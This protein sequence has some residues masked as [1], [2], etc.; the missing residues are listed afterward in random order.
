MYASIINVYNLVSSYA[1]KQQQG[2]ISPTEF[3]SFAES[4]QM[5]VFNDTIKLLSL[6]LFNENRF[7]SYSRGNYGGK[8]NI[9]DDI[10]TLLVYNQPLTYTGNGFDLPEDYAY[11]NDF[12]YK[13]REIQI[14]SPTEVTMARDNML[15]SPSV[16]HPVGV[17]SQR[18]LLVFP[19]SIVTDVKA[20][21]Y[22]YPQSVSPTGVPLQQP[23]FLDFDLSTGIESPKI[24]GYRDFELPVTTEY[25]IAVKI[26]SKIGLNIREEMLIQWV[27]LE[28]IENNQQ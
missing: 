4:A 13:G 11:K 12:T 2:F 3:N 23:P 26:L 21:Y 18:K 15:N 28:E 16:L 27:K 24:T 20:S 19:P 6:A 1:N 10:S 25:K 9:L 17:I 5:E 8:E 22:K 7:M 14:V